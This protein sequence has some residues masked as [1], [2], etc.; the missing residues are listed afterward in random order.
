MLRVRGG[1]DRPSREQPQ[2]F[3][4][5]VLKNEMVESKSD[6]ATY[7]GRPGTE[8]LMAVVQ[9][10]YLQHYRPSATTTGCTSLDQI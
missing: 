1:Y 9:A 7:A 5:I 8:N 2:L 3:L 6:V 10:R 4:N